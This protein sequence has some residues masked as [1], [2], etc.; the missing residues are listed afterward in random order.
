MVVV[1]SPDANTEVTS[2]ATSPGPGAAIQRVP[3]ANPGWFRPCSTT[4]ASC[5]ASAGTTAAAAASAC[6]GRRTARAV[7]ATTAAQIP[8]STAPSRCAVA[9]S[10]AQS[11]HQCQRGRRRS[12]RA[13]TAPAV[14][15]VTPVAPSR[16]SAYARVSWEYTIPNPEAAVTATATQR[17]RDVTPVRRSAV[18]LAPTASRPK[19]ALSAWV[20]RVTVLEPQAIQT[21]SSRAY[22]GVWTSVAPTAKTPDRSCR[23]WLTEKISSFQ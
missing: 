22:K 11:T 6:Q 14:A 13:A 17:A 20:Q 21:C 18:Q 19:T 2:W 23:A 9:A 7:A 4:Q 3:S 12:R 16:A 1:R 10:S 8:T 15:A 5:G